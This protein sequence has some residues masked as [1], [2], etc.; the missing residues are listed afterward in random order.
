M[1]DY[2]VWEGGKVKPNLYHVPITQ[3]GV[4]VVV[5]GNDD[6]DDPHR[7]HHERPITRFMRMCVCTQ[8]VYTQPDIQEKKTT[9]ASP[10][11]Y[12]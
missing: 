9:R 8:C 6:D 3:P 12:R 5:R 4:F 10:E 7:S 1:R 2:G 11:A